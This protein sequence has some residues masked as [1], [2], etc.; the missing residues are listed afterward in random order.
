MLRIGEIAK[1]FDISNRTL[2]YWEEEGIISSIRTENGYRFYDDENA[3]RIKQII[4]LR[5]LRMPIADIERVFISDGYDIAIDALTSHLEK[6]KQEAIVITSLST[7]LE[8]LI[9]QIK[10][11]KNLNQVFLYLEKQ[12]KTIDSEIEKALQ[13]V[14]SERKNNMSVN[15][16][17][18]VRI[19]RLPGMTIA[20]YRAESETPEKD[21]SNVMN[22]FILE[23]SLHKK[24]GFR[25]FGFN[26]PSPSENNPVYGYEI[27]VSIPED[28]NV[29]KPLEKK[30][31]E[32]GL[33]ASITT[34]MGEIGERWQQLY[35]WVKNNDKYDVDF[36]FQWLEECSDFETFISSDESAQ[37]L[38]LLEPIKLR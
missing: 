30:Q 37:Q 8:K 23:N 13:I 29:P 5:K 31:F 17:S 12:S 36:S 32:G 10:A 3:V 15:Q 19:V 16:L 38:D 24:S 28:F 26:N 4:L 1:K 33:Y 9:R 25:H 22:K 2:R 7:V 21:C 20:S 34:K 18:D 11:G 6:L 35:S 14:L 27:W